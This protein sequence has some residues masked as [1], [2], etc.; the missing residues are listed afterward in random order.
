[1]SGSRLERLG[2]VMFIV[3]CVAL[4]AAAVQY[5]LTSRSAAAPVKGAVVAKGTKVTLSADASG[6]ATPS[7]L[8]VLNSQCRFCTQSMPFYG[9]LAQMPGVK[10]G[11]L[12][13]SAI[14]LE[15][16]ETLERYLAT[17]NLRVASVIPIAETGF[18]VS[19]T[20]GLVLASADG[21]VVDSWDGW[22]NPEQEQDV[23][24]A[25]EKL[26]RD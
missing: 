3:M 24:R 15:P 19:G 11:R 26:S 4:T 12:R 14:S 17:H 8:L 2:H 6:R 7:V 23:V 22:L 1:M 20:P 25:I 10:E 9:R 21:V 18:N 5:V 16:A 13:L